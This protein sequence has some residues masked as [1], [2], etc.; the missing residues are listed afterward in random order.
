MIALQT[1]KTVEDPLQT[2][3]KPA[4]L[5]HAVAAWV[6]TLRKGYAAWTAGNPDKQPRVQIVD[7][8]RTFYI[9]DEAVC[10]YNSRF[11]QKYGPLTADNI[12]REVPGT[13]GETDYMIGLG[14][15][16]TTLDNMAGSSFSAY[17]TFAMFVLHVDDPCCTA[18]SL[19]DEVYPADDDVDVD[20]DEVGAVSPEVGVY[21]QLV[22]ELM[23]GSAPGYEEMWSI[24]RM[25]REPLG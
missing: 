21:A 9:T 19:D 8:G 20:D 5:D 24:M 4:D 6:L 18:G 3:N 25:C 15:I 11:Q 7:A 2:K 22:R 10:I 16:S 17:L 12:S 23:F 1:T 13:A 14:L